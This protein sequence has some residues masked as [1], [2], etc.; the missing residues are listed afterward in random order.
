MMET[1]TLKYFIENYRD[2]LTLF[3]QHLTGGTETIHHKP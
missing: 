2:P 3:S 1:A